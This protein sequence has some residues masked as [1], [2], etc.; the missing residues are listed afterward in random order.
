MENSPD[1]LPDDVAALRAELIAVRAKGA[2]IEAE[3]AVAKAKASEDL[4][5]IARQ[6]LRI[7]KLERQLYGPKAERRARLIDQMEFQLAELEMA[8][9]ED[10]LA[11]EMAVAAT[12]NVA[13]FTRSRPA[14]KSFPDHLPRERVVVPGPVSCQCCGGDRLRKLGE[15]I[16]ETLEVIPR[17]WKVIQTV[18]EKFTCRDCEK[19]SQAPA[20]FHAIPRGWAGPNLLAMIL[21]DKFGQHLPLNRQ[22]ERFEREGVSLSLSTVADS[23]G[24]CCAVLDPIIKRIEAHT[25]GADRL[26]GDDTTVPVLAAGKTDIARS[27]V[28]VRDDRPFGGTAAPS[29]M[30]Y[31]SRDRAGEHPQAHLAGYSGILQ[32]DAYTGYT[33][34]Y[35]PDRRPGPITEAA[36]WVHARRPFF[37]MADVEANAR[38]KAQG[39]KAAVISPIALE[40]VERID[41]L[42]DI[43][44]EINGQSVELR[45]AARQDRS[46]PLVLELEAWM[47]AQRAKLSR[48]DDLAKA[49]DYLLKRW[50]A[51]TLFLDDGRVCLSNNAAERALRGIALGRKSWLFAGSDRGGQRAAA[52]YSLIVSAK[53]ND[54]DPQAWLADVLHR[55]AGY[56]A[57]RLDELLPWNWKSASPVAHKLAA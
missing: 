13:G 33:K 34:L 27:W 47:K 46:L 2:Q 8:V 56:P 3:L 1:L 57:H 39:K 41:A 23:I 12:V 30:F 38:R 40:M 22:V 4:A 48:N 31:Y 19:I 16:T 36:C 24:A 28:Y 44:R 55:I 29:A 42:F 21:F 51:F 35:L 43:E 53:M 10:E 20:P 45:K 6:K 26:H 49:F 5:V 37:A 14:K 32:A 9:T 7:E 52:M 17:Q 18:R 54:V 25:F 11:A 50:P 15:D